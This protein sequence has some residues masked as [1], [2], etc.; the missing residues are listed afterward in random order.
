MLIGS[1]GKDQ[2]VP[3]AQRGRN[4]ILVFG[5]GAGVLALA[6]SGTLA[7]FWFAREPVPLGRYAVY[8]PNSVPSIRGLSGPLYINGSLAV[9]GT[10]AGQPPIMAAAPPGVIAVSTTAAAPAVR[11]TSRSD[12]A[13]FVALGNGTFVVADVVWQCGGFA[14]LA[15]ERSPVPDR[16]REG[17]GTTNAHPQ[18]KR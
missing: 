2:E 7:Y 15:G 8:G 3:A 18:R 1:R 12:A 17:T 6:L 9:S 14:V 16:G 4:G 13:Y 10:A 11:I 5:V